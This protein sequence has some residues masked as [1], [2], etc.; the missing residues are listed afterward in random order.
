MKIDKISPNN[1]KKAFEL[2][3]DGRTL[4]FPFALL[5][6]KPE[7]HNR[8]EKVFVDPE[9]GNE[10]F[11]YTINDGREDSIHIDEVLEYNRDP[12]YMRDILLYRL[13][14]EVQKRLKESKLTRREI[15]RRLGTSASQ[16]YRLLDQ[17]NYEKSIDQVLALLTVLGCQVSVMVE[18]NK[19]DG[20]QYRSQ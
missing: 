13:T 19:I 7:A 20:K 11:T 2:V 14:L 6:L 8:I 17:T 4:L 9:L 15:I 10:A 1:R 16:F 5:R 12:N 18:Q 3:V